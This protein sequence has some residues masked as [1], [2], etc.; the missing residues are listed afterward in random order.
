[1]ETHLVSCCCEEVWVSL[2]LFTGVTNSARLRNE[3]ASG[4][5]QAALLDPTMVGINIDFPIRTM[6][7][8]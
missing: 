2:G 5:I 3:A 8:V 4:K 6:C 1:M 7:F